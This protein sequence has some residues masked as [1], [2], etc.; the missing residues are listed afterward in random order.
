MSAS[1]KKKLRKE[2]DAS[3][4][5][6][7]QKQERAEAKKLK[8]YTTVFVA[9]LVL[10]ACT[11]IAVLTVRGI[12]N[13]GVM[14]KNTVAATVG[15]EQLNSV[16]MSYYYNDAINDFYSEM[17]S[18]Y[19]EYA[20]QYLEAIGLDNTK[21]LDEQIYDEES[22]QTWAEYFLDEA[23]KKAQNDFALYK[24]ATEDSFTLPEEEQTT[25]DNQLNNLETYAT[26]YGFSNSKQYL[27]AMYGYGADA[28]SYG[29][30]QERRAVADAYL[31]AHE[32]AL[33]FDD[34]AIREQEAI[35]PNKYTS[36][37]YTSAYLSYTDFRQGGTEDEDGTVTYSDEENNAAR[38]AAKLAAEDMATATTV[39]E[40]NEK[41]EAAEVNED[42]QLAVNEYSDN[43]YTNINA[44]LA[45]WLS[46]EERQE[47]DIEA[48]PNTSTT[49]DEEGNETTVT[50]GYYVAIFHSKNDNAKKMSNV[51]HLLVQ[52]KGGE[53]DETTGETT[54]TEAEM[55][56]AKEAADGYLK[57]WQEGDATEESFIELVKEHSDDTSAEEGGLFENIHP[58]SEYVENFLNWSISADRKPGDAE[59]IETEYGY[60]VMY[61][62]GESETTYRDYMISNELRATTQ[63]E[64]Y[65]GL[66]EAT[67][68]TLGDTSKMKLDVMF[69]G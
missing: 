12:N 1:D 10:I 14:Q 7:R 52:F 65:N 35:N 39:D 46:D 32:E 30:Y 2:Q 38:E 28:K 4:I 17:S 50:N 9:A 37:T 55:A 26:L 27:R 33:T 61:Y 45:Q 59:V 62:V 66:I 60:H 23:L 48:I 68:A 69:P 20:S 6:E 34:A 18:Q 31:T 49:T 19:S 57:Q 67:T 64:W 51:R 15:E 63:E 47:G 53:T 25:L 43:L 13:S 41:V 42:S 24:A 11:A 40:L 36:F 22:G 54:Y 44:T 58:D 21:P 5:T 29:E 8:I 3:I 56:E 16:E